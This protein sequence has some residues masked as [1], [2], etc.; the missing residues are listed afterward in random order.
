MPWLCL[1]T[2]SAMLVVTSHPAPQ[3]ILPPLANPWE[4]PVSS[5]LSRVIPLGPQGW[6]RSRVF[7]PTAGS[8]VIKTALCGGPSLLWCPPAPTAALQPSSWKQVS[9][10]ATADSSLSS[11]GLRQASCQ[12]P[13]STSVAT[14]QTTG[15]SCLA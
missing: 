8:P 13:S 12:P 2:R 3:E 11:S 14:V 7:R 1:P 5:L 15:G 4:P 10:S 9:L 6:S